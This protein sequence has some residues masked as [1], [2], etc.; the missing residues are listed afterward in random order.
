MAAVYRKSL[1]LSNSAKRVK[2][3]GEINNIITVDCHRVVDRDHRINII[4]QILN[5]IKVLKFYAWEKP[6]IQLVDKIRKSELKHMIGANLWFAINVCISRL[7]PLL[8]QLAT[9]GIFAA[10]YGGNHITAQSI[11][12]SLPL[13]TFI[14]EC[15]YKMTQIY[16]STILKKYTLNN[17]NLNITD[18]MFVVIVGSVGSGKSSLLSAIIGEMDRIDGTVNVRHGLQTAYVTQEA[19]IQNTSLKNNI[20]FGKTFDRELYDRVIDNCALRQD[21]SQLSGGDETEIGEKGVNLSGGQ[22]QRLSLARAVYSGADL[23]ILDDPLSAVDSHVSQHIV[24]NILDSNTGI[25]KNKTRILATNQL[26]VLPNADLIVVVKDAK[27][28]CGLNIY[29]NNWLTVWTSNATSDNSSYYLLIFGLIIVAEIV[30]FIVCVFILSLITKRGSYQLH[31]QM[32]ARIMH[33]SI[34]FFDTTPMGRIINRFA[35]DMDILDTQLYQNILLESITRSNINAFVFETLTGLSCIRAYDCDKRFISDF[36]TKTDTNQ[37]C[38]YPNAV[39]NSWLQMR[40][41]VLSTGFV[42]FTALFAIIN[43]TRLTGGDIGLTLSIAVLIM[44][45]IEDFIKTVILF[46]YNMVSIERV[47]EYTNLELESDCQSIADLPDNWPDM[48]CIRFDSYSTRY[49]QGLD[50]VLNNLKVNI[51]ANEKIGIV[52]RTGAGK[53]SLTL[54]LFRL[55]EPSIG[56]IIIDGIDISQLSLHDL[57]SRLTII[58]QEP[59]LFSG[60]IRFNLDPFGKF[61]DDHLWTVLEHSHLKNFVMSSGSGLDYPIAESGDNLSVGQRQLICLSRAL[62]RNTR[63]LILDEATAA[64]DVETDALIQQTIRQEFMSCTV[65]TIAHRINTIMDNNRV[66]VLNGGRIAEFDS[67]D[68]LLANKSSIFYTLA[69][70]A[71]II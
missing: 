19:W 47:D 31:D 59:I 21:L 43:K 18:G 1:V 37:R 32:L 2:P 61:S 67:P 7:V 57:R 56:R 50:L 30:C 17:I 35:K 68:V 54:A 34:N 51:K 33:V 11:F 62:L 39:A 45:I 12:V 23:Y 58:P 65:L 26:F 66:L 14:N 49:R 24:T 71:G 15:L 46:E 10:I 9:F 8:A 40:L 41:S 28:L 16:Y 55:I 36:E 6:F 52:G 13:F 5:G 42:F 70:D 3:I 60:T 29:I 53:S 63:V 22:K 69:R 48:G 25:L 4:S 38:L 20:L 27:R 64:V 44:P